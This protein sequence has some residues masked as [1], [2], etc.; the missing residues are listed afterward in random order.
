MKSIKHK[1]NLDSA[2]DRALRALYRS[3]CFGVDVY[4]KAPH[5]LRVLVDAFNAATSRS[6]SP[7][8]VL[9]YMRTVRK[10]GDWETLGTEARRLDPSEYA[11]PSLTPE[12]KDALIEEY[13]EIGR[14]HGG[15]G[16]DSF[17]HDP[18]LRVELERAFFGRS[19][20]FING[21]L[22]IAV[23]TDI[24]KAGCLEKV[25][26]HSYISQPSFTDLD[27]VEAV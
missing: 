11:I 4:A 14:I 26:E 24:R 2:E 12:E 5:L 7:E 10:A 18:S 8:D 13:L 6:D 3:N 20:R 22:L 1:L 15:I 17:A 21:L 9:H 27:E 16:N 19:A 23:L 25:T